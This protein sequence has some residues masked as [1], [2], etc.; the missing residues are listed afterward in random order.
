LFWDSVFSIVATL[1]LQEMAARL[2][3]ISGHGLGEAL[4]NHFHKGIGKIIAI[5]LAVSAIT[6]GYASFQT[7]NILGET[8]GL[9]SL[10]NSHEPW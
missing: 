1:L 2:R 3:I 4:S 8:L 9:E 10:T 6:I 7:E 5:L